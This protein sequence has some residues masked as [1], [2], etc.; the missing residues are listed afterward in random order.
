M[1]RTVQFIQLHLFHACTIHLQKINQNSVANIWRHL[2]YSTCY[3]MSNIV[4][5]N[6]I[7]S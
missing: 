1:M 6:I 2:L 4:M 7:Q 5:N 3:F